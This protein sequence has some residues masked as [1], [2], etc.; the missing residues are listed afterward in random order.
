MGECEYYEEIQ[1]Q[2]WATIMLSLFVVAITPTLILEY[3]AVTREPLLLGFYLFMD[4][5]FLIVLLNFRKM[6]IRIHNRELVT[7]FGYIRE[8]IKLDNLMSSQRIDARLSVYTGMGIRVGGDG[9]L[10]YLPRLGEAI[11]LE[12]ITGRPF[13]F[14]TNNSK[15]ILE[16]LNQYCTG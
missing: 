8:K 3:V 14:S 11:K 12:Q 7:S 10:A 2:Q 15:Q 16:I 6:S 13:V 5:F 1:L 9:S 4:F